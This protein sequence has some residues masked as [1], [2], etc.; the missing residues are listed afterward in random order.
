MKSERRELG[1]K[2]EQNPCWFGSR[3]W[4]G[5]V[6]IGELRLTRFL[7]VKA[8]ILLSFTSKKRDVV[9]EVSEGNWH[10]FYC[11]LSPKKEMSFPL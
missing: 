9:Y 1:R 2:K 8:Y 5:Y 3:I 11:L 7:K 4:F 10:P 6:R